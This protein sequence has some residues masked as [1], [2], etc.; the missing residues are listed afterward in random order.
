[1]KSVYFVLAL[2]CCPLFG[3]T[4]L[5]ETFEDPAAVRRWSGDR[6]FAVRDGFGV[7]GASAFWEESRIRMPKRCVE[8]QV[9]EGNAVNASATVT[10]SNFRL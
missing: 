10:R 9:I 7:D 6:G 8:G 5:L 2:F 4:V 3:E 1:M